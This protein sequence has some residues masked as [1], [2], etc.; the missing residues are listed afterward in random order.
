MANGKWAHFKI[1]ADD[2]LFTTS[3]TIGRVAQVRKHDLPLLLNTSVMRF[4]SVNAN[5]LDNRYLYHILR[6]NPFVNALLRLKT[7]SG[8]YNVGPTHMKTLK[9]PLPPLE[10]QEQIVA[11]LDGYQKII[12]GAR[13]IVENW[14]P[15]IEID[16]AWERVKLEEVMDKMGEQTDPQKKKG[17]V[18]HVGLENIESG[19]GRIVGDPITKY[20]EIKSLKNT[21]QSRDLLYGKLR[22]NLNKVWLADTDGICSTDILVFRSK[23]NVLINFYW[24]LFLSDDFVAEVMAGIKGAQL[25]RV[26]F[27]Y[28]KN[29]I[30]PRP[31]LDI[32]KKIVKKIEAERA[33]VE[34]AKQLIGIYEEKMKAEIDKLWEG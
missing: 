10:I 27:E 34:S 28:L 4:R 11:E 13:Q 29:I 15:K 31:P 6:S 22:P 1:E 17:E 32:Q 33:L 5:E 14:K 2:I 30:L 12:D 21:F 9:I 18:F 16:P 23:E 3:G 7:G 26:G 25:P 24:Y 8:Q 20:E 19:S